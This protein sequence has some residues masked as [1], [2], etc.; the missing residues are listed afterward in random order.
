M[1]LL[2]AGAVPVDAGKTTFTTG[3]L[4]HT[5]AVG[6]KPRAGNDYWY[7]HDDVEYALDR[8]GLFGSDARRLAAASPGSLAPEDINP[9]H[10]LWRPSP[11]PAQ[12]VLGKEDRE[13]LVDRAGD[14]F[15]VNG[16]VD[17][18]E[19]LTE[20]LPLEG[21]TTVASTEA[22]DAA[23][24]RHHLPALDA[25]AETVAATDRAVV[26]S[27]GDIARPLRTVEPD[28]VAVVEP[29]RARIYRGSRFVRACDV[30]T[31]SPYEGQLEERV[32]S[33]E[34][35]LDPEATVALPPLGGDARGDPSAVAAAYEDAYAALLDVA[36]GW[37]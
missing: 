24:E 19:A 9:V 37:G 35:L 3:L 14:R 7:H 15:V 6:F 10:R 32:G 17:V 27:Y 26:E 12:G 23:T 2:V 22:V 28:A 16:S 31:R 29:R 20:A 13:F 18:P 33:V 30:A 1:T 25:L 4:A 34:D 21:A 8:R 36:E 5:G 11:G